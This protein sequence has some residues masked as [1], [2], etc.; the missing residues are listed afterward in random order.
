VLS[1][2]LRIPDNSNAM[3]APLLR[4]LAESSAECWQGHLGSQDLKALRKASRKARTLADPVI[5]ELDVTRLPSQNPE[6]A[7]KLLGR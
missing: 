7:T 1:I 2:D 3:E 5:T 4:L 6:A